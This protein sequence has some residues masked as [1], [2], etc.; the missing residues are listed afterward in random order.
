MA[1]AS[2]TYT[3][4]S[5]T[6]AF[7]LTNSD[8]DPIGYIRESDIKVTVN[9]SVQASSTYSF[10][11]ATSVEQPSGTTIT[12]NSGV[13][14]TVKLE[15][16]TAIASATVTYTAGSTLTA[17]D[18]NN[19]DNQ[20]RFGLQ[21]FSDDYETLISGTGDLTDLGAF[22]GSGATWVSNNA[23]AATTGAIDGRLVVRL[24]ENLRN[25]LH[26]TAPVTIADDSPSTNQFTIRVGDQLTELATMGLTTA[27]AL[28][29]L[30]NTEV[31]ILD[32]ATL[33][34]AELNHVD[35]VTSNIQ[36]QL[37]GKQ[38]SNQRL[39]QFNNITPNDSVFVV[40]DGNGWVGESGSTARAS[41]GAQ[42]ANDQLT[43]LGTMGATTAEALADLIQSEVQVLDGLTATTAQLNVLN[44]SNA[45]GL[46]AIAA[47]ARTDGNIIVGNGTTWVAENGATARTSLG[48]QTQGA[49]LDTLAGMQEGTASILS[50]GTA[51][52][53]TI[54]ELNILDG[55]TF[56]ES[57]NGS[58]TNTQIPSAQA[59]N[60]Q[61]LAVT[62]ALGGF[63]AISNEGSF[64]NAH[65]DPS[66]NAGTVVSIA[67]VGGLVVNSS[68]VAT[69]ASTVGGT[70]VT[71]NG[72]A[73]AF[74]GTTIAAGVGMQVQTTST[75]NTYDY[76]KAI[77]KES[78]LVNLS[79]DIEDF[80]NRYRVGSSNPTSDNDAGDLF[81]N[82]GSDKMLVRNAANNSW[83]EVQSV[84]NFFI[85]SLSPAFDG[86]TIDFTVTN[87]PANA[88]QIIL[89]INGVIQQPN[90]GT[91]RPTDG[92]SLNGST[93]QLP[94]GTGPAANTPHFVVVLGSTVNIGTPSDNTV[95]VDILQSGC[96]NN[97]KVAANA[98]IAVSKLADFTAN[99]A[100]NR[101]L[102]AT[103]TK[104]SYNGETN[105]VFD[106]TNL[107]IGLTSPSSKLHI[108]TSTN[109]NL[110]VEESSGDLRIS[111]LNDARSANEVLQFAASAFQ[112][113][114]GTVAVNSDSAIAPLNVR[115]MTDGNFHVRPITSIHS[116][117]GVGLD[118]LNNDNSAVQD[119]A[120]RAAN[121]VFRHASAEVMRITSD[122]KVGIGTTSPDFE[123]QVE[124]SS[125]SAVIRAKNGS[126][127]HICD[128]IADGTGGLVRT[129][130]SQPLR[131]DTNQVERMRIDGSSGDITMVVSSSDT[132]MENTSQLILR[133]GNDGANTFAGI[134][135]EVSANAAADHFI[136]QKKHGSGTGT[137]LIVG[138][139]SSERLRFVE[140][141]GITFNGDTAA[142]NALDDYEEGEFD[143]VVRPE[144]NTFSITMHGD[145][146]AYYT[147]VG[148]QV[149]VSGCV[150]WTA[151]TVGN[152]SGNLFIS[153]PFTPAA[154]DNGDNSDDVWA[155][156][157]PVWNGNNTPT[158]GL[159][160]QNSANM[161]LM[162]GTMGDDSI[163]C[164]NGDTGST[165]MVQFSGHF[166][167]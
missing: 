165:G 147:K 2:I 39:D 38:D 157:V 163:S 148:R 144:N 86:S 79:S 129:V 54:T 132:T 73:T 139:G 75:L 68:G 102:T 130:G 32:G 112:F 63:V 117:T 5:S 51:L 133:N 42:A 92:F 37:N 6:T 27:Q 151:F 9:G 24:G 104:N 76:H 82:T 97:E 87:A 160:K 18:L 166:R 114:T 142:A 48:A 95:D 25:N 67:D 138:H 124:D 34:T 44:S 7:A 31:Q 110:E 103:G 52:T 164:S 22:I 65:P 15:R 159:T 136:V 1:F 121:T 11:G 41:L 101:V 83:D 61:I 123:F 143:P 30:T 125:G 45:N 126:N 137:D 89:S 120:I 69:N 33:T 29:D 13:T 118:V 107:G 113:L 50:A 161:N 17:S 35:G 10:T 57:V 106:G 58:S 70:A 153:L 40:G 99:D 167:V 26:G 141:G 20:I 162:H 127:N 131:F 49:R 85:S 74:R 14:G 108:R 23:K 77:L 149:F 155:F 135:F 28:A 55:K 60:T 56:T 134:R 64:P 145:T 140:T 98:A 152:A 93:I 119:L 36:T 100:N 78:D 59:V 109:H 8:G 105:L 46:P 116:G 12:L 4:G 21:E 3:P 96:V 16:T 66:G 88:E 91:G 53:S 81:F 156:R 80:G 84:G 47:L 111:A 122:G 115:A 154:R 43:E 71:I 150:R 90:A 19:A 72:I 94:T 158:M 128:L 146:G 62:N